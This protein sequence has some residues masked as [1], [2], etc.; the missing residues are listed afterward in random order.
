MGGPRT[1]SG[2]KAVRDPAN[3]MLRKRHRLI[4]RKALAF[5]EESPPGFHPGVAVRSLTPSFRRTRVAIMAPSARSL[6]AAASFALLPT[7][8]L[9]GASPAN[10]NYTPDPGL[11]TA[12]KAELESRV[13]RA[14]AATQARLQSA[15][16]GD[17]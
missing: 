10:F 13:R 1:W 7:L 11:K 4:S 16:E 15:A 6:L 14:C 17:A 5:G 8:A 2:G 9:A 12:G 3:M